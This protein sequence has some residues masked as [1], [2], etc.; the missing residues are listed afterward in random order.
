MSPTTVSSVE[1]GSVS[2]FNI[3]AQ[4]NVNRT[5]LSYVVAIQNSTVPFADLVNTL[6]T[7]IDDGSF[8]TTMQGFGSS[9]SNALA[10]AT[11]PNSGLRVDN[12]LD[13]SSSS[14]L[15]G[16]MIAGIVIGIVLFLVLLG[17]S[18]AFVLQHK[19][20][21]AEYIAANT[22]TKPAKPVSTVEMA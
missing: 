14:D 1:F 10:T 20:S 15:T 22:N 8:T 11:A 4:L 12:K 13:T 9:G 5:K 18:I 3:N 21:E 16:A 6:L 2:Y 17:L 19:K 7:A